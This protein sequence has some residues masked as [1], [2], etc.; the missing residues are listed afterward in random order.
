KAEAVLKAWDG[1][2]GQEKYGYGNWGTE[3]GRPAPKQHVFNLDAKGRSFALSPDKYHWA[4]KKDGDATKEA[5]W[6]AIWPWEKASYDKKGLKVM[7]GATPW[8]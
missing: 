4:L 3:G 2:Q 7:I 8:K 5:D 6:L 1:M